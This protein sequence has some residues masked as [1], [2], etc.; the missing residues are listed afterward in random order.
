MFKDVS[1]RMLAESSEKHELYIGNRTVATI[2][3]HTA[4]SRVTSSQAIWNILSSYIYCTSN[5][6]LSHSYMHVTE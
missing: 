3:E 1:N 2:Q 5:K 6:Q 4:M